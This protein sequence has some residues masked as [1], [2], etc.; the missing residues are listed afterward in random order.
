MFCSKKEVW[1]WCQN[2][3]IYRIF[4]V[5]VNQAQ[6]SADRF[7]I[8][9]LEEKDQNRTIFLYYLTRAKFSRLEVKQF[10]W[11]FFPGFL[12]V[13][14]KRGV[15]SMPNCHPIFRGKNEILSIKLL[16]FCSVSYA[17]STKMTVAMRHTFCIN[18][19]EMSSLLEHWS[20]IENK[21]KNDLCKNRSPLKQ[22]FHQTTSQ[23]VR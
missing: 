6:P 9:K 8:Y 19:S 17:P 13:W 15:K 7:S 5:P 21:R 14:K 12:L 20:K 1:R 2:T 23:R 22:L 10:G 3:T 11:N 18:L 16:E 4:D